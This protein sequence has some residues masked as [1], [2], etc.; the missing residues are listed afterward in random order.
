MTYE[1][2]PVSL[3]ISGLVPR[4]RQAPPVP[5]HSQDDPVNVTFIE[6]YQLKGR[7][8]M[9]EELYGSA[10]NASHSWINGYLADD[11]P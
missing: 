6:L 7:L 5:H 4:L 9:Y 10:P 2:L 3:N 1:N 11:P 8:W